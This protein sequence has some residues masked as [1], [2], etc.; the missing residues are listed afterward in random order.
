M[1]GLRDSAPLLDAYLAYFERSRTPF[2]IPGHKQK[3][4]RLDQAL[5]AVVDSDIPLYGGLD[6]IKL[7]NQTLKKAESLAAKL[8]GADY[9]RFSTGGSTH[10]NQ[11]IIFALG[12]PGDK[13]AVSRT[14][15]R[16]VLSALV[17]AG[18][19]PIWMTPEI[20][21]KTGVPI[22]IP[23]TELSSALA[24]QPIAVLL[25]EPG[26][27]GTI[28][29]LPALI[30]ASHKQKV[31]VILD[32]A[33]GGHFGFNPQ[34]PQHAFQLGA[35]ALITS[36]H[37]ALPGYSASALLLARTEFLSAERLEQSFETTHTTSPAGA[38]LASIDGVR[39]L[40]ETRGEELIG[41]LLNNIHR[42]KESVQAEF[43]LPIF[44]YAADFPQGRFDPSK[45]VLRVQQLG[46]S[47]IEIEEDLQAAGIRVE[48]ADR[49]TIVF[50][51]TIADS[52]EDFDRLADALIP[53][54]KKRQEQRRES[55]TAL[56]WSVIPQRGI[57]MR[58]AY[59][60]KTEM[61]NARDAIGRISA[62]LI[63]P[64]PPGVAV[65]APGEILTEQIVDGLSA[66]RKAGV[67][68]A[69]ATDSTL[70]QYRVVIN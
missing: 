9:A 22:G 26:Y 48:M 21:E 3:T 32:A 58:D 30:S 39:A 28:S 61:V 31:P 34:L 16:S 33:W 52:T 6:E 65:V 1:S 14:A 54:L 64:Y 4:S 11:A 43:P 29:D 49:D 40:L 69:Y 66:S 44:L 23:L 45:I 59:F 70:A 13:V 47:G 38:P 55:A 67:R 42:F 37:K 60:A 19:E 15:H 51:G 7:T 63:A 35:D 68:I 12:K 8:W 17:L 62:D 56:S 24:Q 20:D 18:L 50:L 10:A 25:T 41:Q 53:I 36:T 57:S 5:G 2:T 46:A 27:L